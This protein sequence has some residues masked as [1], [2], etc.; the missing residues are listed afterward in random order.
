MLRLVFK[1]MSI[2]TTLG[3]I[4]GFVI[5]HCATGCSKKDTI[6]TKDQYKEVLEKI[7]QM[8]GGQEIDIM[9]E[10]G[11]FEIT[12]DVG[13]IELFK[14]AKCRLEVVGEGDW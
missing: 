3:C 13:K 14:S 4:A 2:I 10:V 9:R 5:M 12:N 6:P 7:C 8:P 11:M 1:P